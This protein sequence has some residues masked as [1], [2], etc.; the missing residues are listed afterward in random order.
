MTTTTKESTVQS[1]LN[2]SDL[3]DTADLLTAIDAGNALSVVKATFTG[4]TSLAA[5]D[6]TNDDHKANAV[7]VGISPALASGANLPAIGQVLSLRITAGTAGAG[8]SIVTDVGGTPTAI[9]ALAA[10]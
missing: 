7:V 9:A 4:L 3:N 2:G 6:I 5:Q 1:L 8:P 10:R